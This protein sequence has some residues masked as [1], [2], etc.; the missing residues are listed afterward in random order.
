LPPEAARQLFRDG[1][2]VL[3]PEPA[4]VALVRELAAPRADGGTLPLRLYRAAGTATAE[5]LPALVYFH[6]GG[7]VVGDLG[8][9]D[10]LCRHLANTAGCAVVAVEYRLAPEH[11][12]PAAVD[13][14]LSATVF[15]A[16]KA[17]EL[18]VDGNCLAVGGDSAGGNLAAVVALLV[19]ERGAP[20]LRSQV[21]IYPATDLGVRHP[22]YDLFAEDYLLTRATMHWFVA[23]YLRSPQDREDWRASPL[24]AADLSGLPPAL[25]LTAG[26]DPLRDEG[27]AYAERL[28][29]AGVAVRHRPYPD[30]IHGF[31]T[32][33]KFIAAAAPA[34]DEIAA[35][36]REAWS[37]RG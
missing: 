9:H 20:A 30:Q 21:L 25:V 12:F 36:L 29:A 34:I 15:V 4:A 27:D 17:D 16:D 2:R 11:P 33:G 6:G 8:T 7:W 5:R 28:R 19:R 10:S 22:S 26:F 31:V 32:M 1:Q 23:H 13:D 37:P 3:A 35:A 24:L 14:A 18:G